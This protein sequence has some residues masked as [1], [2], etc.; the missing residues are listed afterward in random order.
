MKPKP[1]DEDEYES[2]RDDSRLD[3][4][5]LDRIWR[6]SQSS[7]AGSSKEGAGAERRRGKLIS[8]LHLAF[9]LVPAL[10]LLGTSECILFLLGEGD[11][12]NALHLSRG[13]DP[14]G[15]Y[16][17]PD[18]SAPGAYRKQ[19]FDGQWPEV[20][21]PPKSGRFR[22]ALFGGSNT[23]GFPHA[24]LEQELNRNATPGAGR[25]EVVN[26]GRRGYG[27]RRVAILC[28]QAACVEPDLYLIYSGH[29]E[30]VERGFEIDLEAQW[31]DDWIQRTAKVAERLRTFQVLVAWMSAGATTASSSVPPEQWKWEH[32]KFAAFTYEQARERFELYRGNLR[33][34]IQSARARG[35]KVL[36][37]TLI[38]NHFSMPYA[39][40][41]G[42]ELTAQEKTR[43]QLHLAEAQAAIPERFHA[44]LAG[45]AQTRILEPDWRSPAKD[46]LQSFPEGD[47]LRADVTRPRVRE[48]KW[49][50]A[51]RWSPKVVPFLKSMT[52]FHERRLEEGE[53]ARLAEAIEHLDQALGICADH[54]IALYASAAVRYLHGGDDE[55]AARR[56]RAAA[57]YD[58]APRKANDA[59]ND[60]VRE[61]AREF[62]ADPAVR[63]FDAEAE[64]RSRVPLGLIG[65]EWMTDDCHLHE[66][67][68]LEL[69]REFAR[70]L[71][72]PWG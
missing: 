16:L 12:E 8:L 36:L 17:V 45:N 69:M 22:I 14:T 44:I 49:P 5:S 33:E 19:M 60:I 20:V 56:F 58:R 29:N 13:F 70:V 65:W 39:S 41:F 67:V 55:E 63:F 4:R 26:L 71:L 50:P 43:F 11:P 35:A 10:I 66:G 47:L 57:R 52:L 48:A 7:A 40:A 2:L 24:F 25:F 21:I 6:Q 61:V 38:A 34:M 53:R 1:A 9:A 23:Q 42:A 46:G 62:T 37:S 72:E 68:K 51:E 32:D 28:A 3:S 27:S 18:D 31:S 30:F 15:R 59:I 54:P 64:F